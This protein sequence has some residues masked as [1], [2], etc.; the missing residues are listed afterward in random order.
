MRSEPVKNRLIQILAKRGWNQSDLVRKTG[1]NCSQI[2]R[3]ISG[4]NQ[5]AMGIRSAVD[6]AD[7]LDVSLDELLCRDKYIRKDNE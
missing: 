6:I 1:I 7:A 5:G 2:S 4:N 3:F